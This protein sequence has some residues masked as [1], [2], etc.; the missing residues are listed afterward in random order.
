[1]IWY[2]FLNYF[3]IRRRDAFTIKIIY[4]SKKS[5]LFKLYLS[6]I[7]PHK[8]KGINVFRWRPVYGHKCTFSIPKISNGLILM[9]TINKLEYIHNKMLCFKNLFCDFFYHFYLFE[10]LENLECTYMFSS[11]PNS[12]KSKIQ[13]HLRHYCVSQLYSID[14]VSC[15]YCRVPLV[16]PLSSQYNCFPPSWLSRLIGG[17]I[18]SCNVTFLCREPH[19]SMSSWKL[20]LNTWTTIKLTLFI[21]PPPSHTITQTTTVY[22]PSF[23]YIR[24]NCVR[25]SE[26]DIN[27]YVLRYFADCLG[28]PPVLQFPVEQLNQIQYVHGAKTHRY[29]DN[30]PINQQRSPIH[31]KNLVPEPM[32]KHT[33]PHTRNW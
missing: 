19:T 28:R 14:C 25:T 1:M 8:L 9:I 30:E 31:M 5:N 24:G 4:Y 26:K 23:I 32:N 17:R 21:C 27:C 3:P 2:I 22:P 29:F 7:K 11:E 33:S 16:K 13:F 12:L 15:V 18:P 20:S 6:S 10:N